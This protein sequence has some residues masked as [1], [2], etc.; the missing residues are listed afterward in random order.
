MLHSTV[1]SGHADAVLSARF[2]PDGKEIVTASRDRTAALWD[3]ASGKR[4]R[5][6][7]EG[8]EF[9]ATSAVFFADGRRLATGAGDNTVRIWDVA[10]GTQT[11]R[12]RADRPARHAR[13]RRPAAI[14][15][16][17]AAPTND[18]KIWDAHSGQSLA[19]LSGHK[20][21]ISA[22]AFSPQGDLLATGD[23][24]GE[25][26]LWHKEGAPGQWALAHE[27]RGHSRTITAMKFTPDGKR[28]VSSS[29]DQTCASGT[30]PP[31]KSSSSSC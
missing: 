4:L 22:A 5:Q 17:P 31:A 21:E 12:A 14:G 1:F 9:L 26:R 11:G 29:G 30:L 2:S 13:R 20:A 8:H 27:L 28:L 10:L 15:S 7:E 23:D 18:A 24:H 25:I 6:F 3:V 19:N 16:S